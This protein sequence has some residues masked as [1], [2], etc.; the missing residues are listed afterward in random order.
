MLNLAA[1]GLII[2][3]SVWQDDGKNEGL[4]FSQEDKKLVRG[5][6][7]VKRFFGVENVVADK[8]KTKEVNN[9]NWFLARGVFVQKVVD[10]SIREFEVLKTKE[11]FK[12]WMMRR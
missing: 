12:N 11:A 10:E 7:K 9:A 1:K 8:K 4:Y 3:L 6:Y 2:P 5:P